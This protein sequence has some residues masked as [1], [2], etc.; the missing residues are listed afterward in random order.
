[1]KHC[2]P[3]GVGDSTW[4]ESLNSFE[5]QETMQQVKFKQKHFP[6]V[7]DGVWSKRPT[8][9]YPHILPMGYEKE[10][11]YAPV[12]QDILNYCSQEDI[13]IHTEVLN[14][15]SSQ[16]ACFN[17]LFPLRQ[18]LKLAAIA[19]APLLPG[20]QQVDNIEFEYTGPEGA[21]EWL[22]EPAGGKRGQN[23][24]SIDAAI[25]WR[26]SGKRYLTL[27]EWKYTE[28]G[29]GGCGGYESKGNKRK[30][31]CR[32]LNL[33]SM[34]PNQ[35]YLTQGKNTRRYWEHLAQAEIDINAMS[36]IKGCPFR[37]PFYQLMRQFL[38]AAYLRKNG[39]Q[40]GK[41]DEVYVVSVSFKDNSFI[42][43]VPVYLKQLGTTVEDAW[44]SVLS[45][46]PP[47][48]T[49]YAN[50]IVDALRGA[51]TS[52]LANYLQVRYGL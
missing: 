25:T 10:V 13:A 2:L 29:Y 23:R 30:D 51:G 8:Y 50:D 7:A 12:A 32:E 20:V 18:D 28:R 27:V 46:V 44:N 45:N 33:G 5:K 21:T 16:V 43:M 49:V 40:E 48:S 38:L 35:C 3:G 14:L 47:L 22:G 34:S 6:G 31:D 9:T 26:A 15:R 17:V 42:H 52:P 36:S 24:T 39:G 1:M 41:F 19:L 11:F 4:F 37:G